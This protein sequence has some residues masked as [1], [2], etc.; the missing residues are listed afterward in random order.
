MI[1]LFKILQEKIL[2]IDLID[3]ANFR[4]DR[5]LLLN[6]RQKKKKKINY[7]AFYAKKNRIF[8]VEL[9]CWSFEIMTPNLKYF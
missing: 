7:F 1:F 5:W 3:R 6:F 8:Y 9:F 2:L 4:N